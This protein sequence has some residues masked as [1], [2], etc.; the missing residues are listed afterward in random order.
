[1][2]LPLSQTHK[3]TTAQEH[4]H[5]AY[6]ALSPCMTRSR[7]HGEGLTKTH[8]RYF[9]ASS[10]FRLLTIF[11]LPLFLLWLQALAWH[12]SAMPRGTSASF[13]CPIRSPGR[14]LTHCG[15]C[16]LNNFELSAII[17]RSSLG[18]RLVPSYFVVV[19]CTV[20]LVPTC[21]QCQLCRSTIPRTTTTRPLPLPRRPP[22]PCGQTRYDC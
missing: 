1:M 12:I 9:P 19:S 21:G 16:K 8:R 2:S 7:R 15:T 4:L 10:F 5:L 17:H 11:S 20:C 6:H 13:I 14:K 18:V 3:G 22:M